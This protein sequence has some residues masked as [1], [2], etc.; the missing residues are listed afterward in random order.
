MIINYNIFI[1]DLNKRNKLMSFN[2]FKE[3]IL[4]EIYMY[5]IFAIYYI[6]IFVIWKINDIL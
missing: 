6:E 3:M 4:A 1:I 2:L 5:Y